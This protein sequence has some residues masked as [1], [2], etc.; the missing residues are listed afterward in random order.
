[1]PAQFW[2]FLRAV[3]LS[4]FSKWVRNSDSIWAYPTVLFFH[5]VGLAFVVGMSIAI[6]LRVLG[7]GSSMPTKPMDQFF[8]I[9]WA[10]FWLNAA[11]GTILVA[12]DATYKFSSPVFWIKMSC[13]ALAVITVQ[14]TR[15]RV[16]RDK[17]IDTAGVPK[18]ARLLAASSIFLW[19]A[20]I[21]TGRLLA[22]LTSTH[23][24]GADS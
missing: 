2:A 13:I 6:S 17:D 16:F 14:A 10:G 18:S 5:T 9:I 21:V 1:M 15:N 4:G 8:P 3:E 23:I 19:L 11:S 24:V 22:Y 20:A 12:I 7:F